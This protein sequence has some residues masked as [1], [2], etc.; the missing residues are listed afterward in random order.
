LL[1]NPLAVLAS[2]LDTW[3]KSHWPNL[4]FYR[5]DLLRAPQLL[6]DGIQYVGDAAVVVRYEELVTDPVPVLE[7]LCKRLGISFDPQMLSYG[8]R[9][10]PP[11]NLGD[12]VGVQYR[13]RPETGSLDKWRRLGNSSQGRHFAQSLL[14]TLGPR[15]L[16]DLGYP[17]QKLMAA[18]EA[19][20]CRTFWPVFPWDIAVKPANEWTRQ[21]YVLAAVVLRLQLSRTWQRI[22]KSF[23]SS[24][25]MDA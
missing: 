18:I 4:S 22:Q 19:V 7:T 13:S 12:P 2:I 25:S 16:N 8:E 9:E 14:E 15:L 20:H 21:E 6:L 5:D 1:R 17:Y 11:G 10:T 23:G 3:V 24:L